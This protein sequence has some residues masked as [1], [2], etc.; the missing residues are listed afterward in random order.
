M[1]T[2][3]IAT[4][5]GAGIGALFLL[6]AFGATGAPQEAAAAA[7]AVAF[8]VIP[9]CVA[10]TVHRREMRRLAERAAASPDSRP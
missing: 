8:T 9:Y 2:L 3:E 6:L 7:L 1:K 10:S 4:F 5:I